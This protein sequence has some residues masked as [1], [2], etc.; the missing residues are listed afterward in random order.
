LKDLLELFQDF[1]FLKIKFNFSNKTFENQHL[2]VAI[3]EFKK[4]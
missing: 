4:M 3:L 2:K 1:R